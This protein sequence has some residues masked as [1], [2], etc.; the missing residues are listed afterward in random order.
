MNLKR[1]VRVLISL[2]AWLPLILGIFLMDSASAQTSITGVQPQQYAQVTQD[3]GSALQEFVGQTQLSFEKS[4]QEANQVLSDLPQQLERVTSEPQPA[5]REQIEDDLEDRQD[6]LENLADT[7]DDLAEK[8][9]SYNKKSL[10]SSQPQQNALNI[11][12]SLEN[13]AQT[14]DTLADDVEKAKENSS[15]AF[16]T[17]IGQKIEAVNQALEGA[18]S[19][20]QSF[21]QNP[22]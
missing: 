21:T 16:R 13:V 19:A 22:A 15:A 2:V 5:V 17:Q 4:L 8:V 11:Q 18:N 20:F 12:Q 10:S 6:L 14:I 3:V 9:Q 1:K 7:V